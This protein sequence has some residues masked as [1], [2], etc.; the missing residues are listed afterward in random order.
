MR[1]YS[2][3]LRE[4]VLADCDAGAKTR[5]V[6]TKF[7]VSESWVRRLKQ[8]RAATGETAPRPSRN[9][10]VAFR[11]RHA[12]ALRAAVAADPD[13]TLAELRDHLGVRVSLGTLWQAPADLKIAWKKSP[14]GR[15]SR[16][17]RT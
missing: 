1:A 10:R 16:G 13:R 12:E 14:S 11:D 4:R 6:A 17:G 15:P 5:A 8:R 2:L 3:D 9:R 7:R